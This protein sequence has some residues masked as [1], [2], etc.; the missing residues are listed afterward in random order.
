MVSSHYAHRPL[1]G[2]IP[3]HM[4]M[5]LSFYNFCHPG[6]QFVQG[7]VAAVRTV[8][9]QLEANVFA[10]VLQLCRQIDEDRKGSISVTGTM[11]NIP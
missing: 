1:I 3:I 7:I 9:R 10:R 11:T 6:K 8:P 4:G 2:S 5:D